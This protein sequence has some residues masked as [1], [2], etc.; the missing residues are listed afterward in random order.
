MNKHPLFRGLDKQINR[1]GYCVTIVMSKG[2]SENFSKYVYMYILIQSGY[3]YERE[4]KRNDSQIRVAPP[5][6]N[7]HTKRFIMVSSYRWTK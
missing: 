5:R 6:N 2:K 4:G 7:T 1:Y 3:I